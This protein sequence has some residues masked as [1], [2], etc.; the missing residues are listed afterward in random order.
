MLWFP[1]PPPGHLLYDFFKGRE[2]NPRIGNFDLKFFCEMRPG[3][4]GWVSD[5]DPASPN[6]FVPLWN[7]WKSR[8]GGPEASRLHTAAASVNGLLL[9]LLQAL[10]DQE[11]NLVVHQQQQAAS[12]NR[13]NDRSTL[14]LYP[15]PCMALYTPPQLPLL[16]TFGKKENKA[17][18]KLKRAS[19]WLCLAS[20]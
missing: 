9:L 3:L 15:H 6:V 12:G 8:A 2:L 17:Q 18:A 1:P 19:F 14:H 20:V 10:Q 5:L 11:E 4:I 16:V 7:G 13:L